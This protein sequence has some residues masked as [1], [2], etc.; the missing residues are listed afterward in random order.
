[1]LKSFRNS[2][3][4]TNF[5]EENNFTES[6]IDLPSYPNIVNLNNINNNNNNNNTYSET[7]DVFMSQQMGGAND[8]SATSSVIRQSQMGG[9]NNELSAT[10]SFIRQSQMGGANDF[11][12]TSS[13]IRQ[14]QMGGGNNELSATSS[15]IRQSQMGGANDFSATSSVIRQSQMGGANDFSATS[16]NNNNQLGGNNNYSITSANTTTEQDVNALLEMLT[17]ENFSDSENTN[18]IEEKLRNT[19]LVGGNYNN[20]NNNA[21]SDLSDINLIGGGIRYI[22]DEN[23]SIFQNGGAEGKGNGFKAFLA[24]KKH[25]AEKL[26]ISNGI[27]AGRIAGTVLREIKS[28]YDNI[29]TI[30]AIEKAKKHFE[31][32]MEKYRKML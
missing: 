24:F 2:N 23:L 25:V 12:A 11:S 28:K 9:G 26:G 19:S 32:N 27:P 17:S 29:N 6:S 8:F 15:F 4:K 30:D 16:Y 13:V 31:K 20:N 5:K 21:N 1:M 14:S 22:I 7:S 3:S 18:V 10:S